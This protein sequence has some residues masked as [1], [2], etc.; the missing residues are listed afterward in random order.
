MSTSKPQPPCPVC[1]QPLALRIARG[2]KSGK[3]FLML[4]CAEDAR[5]FR[6]F[7]NDRAYVDGVL[8]RLEGR[9]ALDQGG[10]DSIDGKAPPRRSKTNLEQPS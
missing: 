7:I 5:H 9:T 10:V 8:S 4:L 1:R 2:R 6:G 3:T